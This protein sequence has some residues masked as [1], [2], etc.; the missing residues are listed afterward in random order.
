MRGQIETVSVQHLS[1]TLGN[2]PVVK[3]VSFP[4]AQGDVRGLV[5]LVWL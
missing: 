3:D 2:T 5:D 1:K 4:L